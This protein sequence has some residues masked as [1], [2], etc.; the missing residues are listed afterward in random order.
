MGVTST[1]DTAVRLKC[2]SAVPLS[3]SSPPAWDNNSHVSDEEPE[4]HRNDGTRPKV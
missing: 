3:R 4:V 2:H 1:W